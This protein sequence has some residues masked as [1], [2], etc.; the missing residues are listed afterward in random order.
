MSAFDRVLLATEHTAQDRGAESLAL[1]LVRRAP[2]ALQVVMPLASNPEYE[3]T[4]PDRAARAEADFTARREAL[5]AEA[6]AAGVALEWQ[7]RRGIEPAAEIVEHARERAASLL[8]IRRRGQRGLLANLLVGEMV[9][10]VLAHAPCSTL[11][12]PRE[13]TGLWQR[14]VLVAVEPHHPDR[15]SVA[16]AAAIARAQALPLYLVAVVSR[17]SERELATAALHAMD[18]DTNGVHT[19]HVVRVGAAPAEIVS[20]AQAHAADLIVV[21]R[22]GGAAAGRARVGSVAQKVIGLARC[23]VLV[24]IEPSYEPSSP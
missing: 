11:V 20:Q 14:A 8:V 9:S 19:H 23:P 4:V 3:A 12:V 15:P 10:Q 13:V 2:Q 22:H 1:A 16:R 21:T 24:V 17:E 7:V 5:L 18:T 6:E